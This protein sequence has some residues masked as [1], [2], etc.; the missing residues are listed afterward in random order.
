MGVLSGCAAMVVLSC[1]LAACGSV[2]KGTHSAVG[3][4]SN[5]AAA[6]GAVATTAS[7]AA[8][9]LERF[10]G[11]EDDDESAGLNTG[12]SRYDNDAD[13]DNDRTENENKGYY[14]GDDNAVRAY[15]HAAS[16]AETGALTAFVKRYYSAALASDGA[17]ACSM[18]KRSLARAMP[19]DYGRPPGPPYLRGSTCPA[20]M[21][22]YFKHSHGSPSA[23]IEVTGVRVEGPHAFVL[24]GSRTM[25]AS[26]AT[27]EREGGSWRFVGMLGAPLP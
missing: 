3:A 12:D 10:K 19:E 26:Y 20:V 18:M 22:L 14:D 5:G 16:A 23:A 17:S 11:D 7:K 15:G 2:G 21:S 4:S 13:G 6:G 25:P 1:G 24:L 27:L 9:A 8:L